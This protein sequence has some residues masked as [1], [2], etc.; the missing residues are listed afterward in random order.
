M[1]WK[2]AMECFG[3]IHLELPNGRD[4]V[5]KVPRLKDQLKAMALLEDMARGKRRAQLRLV[6]W[7]P[8]LVGLEEELNQLTFE[9]F[10]DVVNRFFGR[11]G[12]ANSPQM[13]ETPTAPDLSEPLPSMPDTT[14]ARPTPTCTGLIS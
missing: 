14:D 7:F 1:A 8:R 5:G 13:A 6:M 12:S 3:E 9:E 11:R 2:N 4:V 10:L